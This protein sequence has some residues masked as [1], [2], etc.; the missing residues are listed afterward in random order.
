MFY[1]SG[2]TTVVI[3]KLNLYVGIFYLAAAAARIKI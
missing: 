2:I 3:L 1:C